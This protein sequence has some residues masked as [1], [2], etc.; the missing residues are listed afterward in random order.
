MFSSSARKAREEARRSIK[1][2]LLEAPHTTAS[3]RTAAWRIGRRRNSRRSAQS[4]PAGWSP[5]HRRDSRVE[6][7]DQWALSARVRCDVTVRSDH[8]NPLKISDI[9][10]VACEGDARIAEGALH[11]GI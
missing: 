11:R 1:M 2:W 9:A 4:S 10:A 3:D 8:S 5:S 7:I 6:W